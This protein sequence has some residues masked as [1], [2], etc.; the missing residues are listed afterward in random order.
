MA[1]DRQPDAAAERR[2][3]KDKKRS[4]RDGVHKKDRKD[5]KEKKHK[6]ERLAEA[7]E[8]DEQLQASAASG[9]D[10]GRDGDGSGEEGEEEEEEKAPATVV[11]GALVEFAKPMAA[12]KHQRKI[13]KG[14]KKAAKA[15]A[16]LRGVKEVNKALR[17]APAKTPST[18]HVVPGIVIIA[19][20]ISPAEVVM[21]LPLACE[22]VNAPYMFVASRAE[23]GAAAKTKRPT[24]VVMLLPQGRKGKKA[25]GDKDGETN[26]DD[27][28]EAYKELSK[29]LQKEFEKQMRGLI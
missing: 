26:E 5:K 20:D 9:N 28:A 15:Q 17:K 10:Q 6:K 22:D 19:G 4:E 25:D 8:L 27:Y 1:A 2:K 24:S 12:D 13:Y 21:H 11:R 29:T 16:L 23:L 14:V 3:Q 7:L 18:A